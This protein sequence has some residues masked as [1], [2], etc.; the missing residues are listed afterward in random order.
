[1][2]KV[3]GT[4]QIQNNSI[5]RYRINIIISYNL[6]ISKNTETPRNHISSK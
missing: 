6:S 4:Q 1:M 3:S 2:K 5:G